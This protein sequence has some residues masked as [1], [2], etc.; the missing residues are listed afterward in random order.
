[1]AR[2]VCFKADEARERRK[3]GEMVFAYDV[4]PD[5]GIK[6]Y[7]PLTP[8]EAI[9]QLRDSPGPVHM[10]EYLG[11][12]EAQQFHVDVDLKNTMGAAPLGLQDK[13]LGVL[14]EVRAAVNR[15]ARTW[16]LDAG[17]PCYFNSSTA[18]G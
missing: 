2:G 13:A 12:D 4:R 17:E 15:A 10:Y 5:R 11:A 6:C 7:R 16:G 9:R 3:A 8:G 1:M 18:V 14:G